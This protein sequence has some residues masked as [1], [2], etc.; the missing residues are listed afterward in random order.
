MCAFSTGLYNLYSSWVNSKFWKGRT[1]LGLLCFSNLQAQRFEIR[2]EEKQKACVKEQNEV[3]N[4]VKQ[5]MK[6]K[7]LKNNKWK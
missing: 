3:M 4:E 7:Q 2:I 6:L 5:E 1:I